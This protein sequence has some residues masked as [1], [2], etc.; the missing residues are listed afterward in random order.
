MNKGGGPVYEDMPERFCWLQ[1]AEAV[2]EWDLDKL[3]H[4]VPYCV[5]FEWL[6]YFSFMAE[7]KAGTLKQKP[8]KL[9]G[10]EMIRLF[11]AAIGAKEKKE[12]GKG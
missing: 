4:T 9:S 10:H 3:E 8:V 11:A 5:L 7:A 12:D 1:M 6:D 2:G